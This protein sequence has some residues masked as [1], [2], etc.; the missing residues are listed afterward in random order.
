VRWLEM[1]RHTLKSLGPKVVS[2]RMLRDY[3]EQLYAP[4]ARTA[5]AL[6]DNHAGALSLA[7]WKARLRAGWD[8]VSVG[9]VEASGVSDSP[10]VGGSLSVR[11]SV[12]LG[13][14]T[15]N[16]VDVQVVHGRVGDDDTL[17]GGAVTSL[18][19]AESYGDGW[20]RFDGSVTLDRTGPFGYTVRVLPRH[21]L[22]AAP[23][24][25]GLVASPEA[26]VAAPSGR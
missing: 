6:N 17:A 21:A 7:Q 8:G 19:V 9:A 14:I 25:M 26:R 23:A 5:R 16:D 11:V 13:D 22:L 1:M 10:E 12:R 4:T 18:S 24:E 3:V 2:T 15:P 20:H